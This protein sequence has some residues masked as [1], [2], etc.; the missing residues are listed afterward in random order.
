M[1]NKLPLYSIKDTSTD[2]VFE[3]NLRFSELDGYL[4]N[5]PN[6]KQVFTKFPGVVDPTRLGRK[7]PDDGFKDVL[8]EVKNHHKRDN[9]NTW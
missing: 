2:D 4:S 5:N 3:V 6:Y 9:I 8:R 7:K 1:E